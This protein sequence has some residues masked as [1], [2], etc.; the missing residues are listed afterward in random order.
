[1]ERLEEDVMSCKEE[2]FELPAEFDPPENEREAMLGAMARC[3]VDLVSL[4]EENPLTF[5]I[6]MAKIKQPCLSYADIAAMFKCKKQNVQYHLEKAVKICPNLRG[7]ILV[8]RRF[9]RKREEP[10]R[11]PLP[12]DLAQAS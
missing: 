6:T 1:M 12:P 9:S 7:A 3:V 10:L 8:D 4:F 11:M 5:R 2:L